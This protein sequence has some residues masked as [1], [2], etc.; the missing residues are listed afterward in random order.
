MDRLDN[1][2]NSLDESR[3]NNFL[4]EAVSLDI[5]GKVGGAHGR[6]QLFKIGGAKAQQQ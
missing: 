3:S 1:K 6:R 5:R 2:D 4:A